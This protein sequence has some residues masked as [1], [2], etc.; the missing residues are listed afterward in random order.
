MPDAAS[1]TVTSPARASPISISSTDHG[2]LIPQRIAPLVF[3]FVYTPF[4]VVSPLP[5]VCAT[6]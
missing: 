3:T 5:V 1:S 2:S 6:G 4:A